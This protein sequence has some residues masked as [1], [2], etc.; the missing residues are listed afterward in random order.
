M[1]RVVGAGLGRTGT[2]SLKAALEV[3][4]GG[5]CYHMAEVAWRPDD[6]DLWRAAAE[7]RPV[8]WARCLDGYVATV[9][10]PAAAFWRPLGAAHPEAV[11]LLS[12]RATPEEWWRSAR[13]TILANLD[14]P[15]DEWKARRPDRAPWRDMWDALMDATFTA[16]YLD[17][18]QAMAS[19]ERHNRQVREEVDADRLLEWQPGDGWEP[20]CAA[21]DLPVP[22]RPFPH[23]NTTDDW[24]AR[25]AADHGPGASS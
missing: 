13:R 20:L 23:L 11:V 8:D 15:A 3:L 18:E 7:G 2:T 9:D 1:L 12:T 5:R 16:A 25:A 10:W 22:D 4:L 6:P 14:E 21:L 24:L 19:Y 17:P